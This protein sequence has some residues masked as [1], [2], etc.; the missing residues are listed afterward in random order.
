MLHIF[1]S[2]HDRLAVGARDERGLT[3]LAYAL[4][5]AVIIVPIALA[6]TGFGG[7]VAT[8]AGDKIEALTP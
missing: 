6:M 3:M 7:G 4:G 8:E 2:L 5:A 1:C